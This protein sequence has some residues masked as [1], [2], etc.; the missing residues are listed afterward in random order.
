MKTKPKRRRA[1]G[2]GRKP[3]DPSGA[4][5]PVKIWLSPSQIALLERIGGTAQ[6]GLRRLIDR[7][8]E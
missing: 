5:A 1:P 8:A 7:A 4:K 6:E 3:D 2:G